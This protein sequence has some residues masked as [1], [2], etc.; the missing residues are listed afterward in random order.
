MGRAKRTEATTPKT[1]RLNLRVDVAAAKRLAI[2]SAMEGRNPGAVVSELIE[3]HLKTWTVRRLAG[4]GSSDSGD[5][6]GES[7]GTAPPNLKV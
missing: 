7:D 2:H 4:S 3:T 5:G 1:T 6:V